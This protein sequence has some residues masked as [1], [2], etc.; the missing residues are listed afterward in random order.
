MFSF[1]ENRNI[2]Q[3]AWGFRERSQTEIQIPSE[4][5]TAVPERKIRPGPGRRLSLLAS[6]NRKALLQS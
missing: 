3:V 1:P 5:Q 2:C 6:D 4:K